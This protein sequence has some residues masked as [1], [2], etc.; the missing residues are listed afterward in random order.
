VICHSIAS[1]QM[2][3]WMGAFK[4]WF[5]VVYTTVSG[6]C[7]CVDSSVVGELGKVL[8]LK[9]VEGYKSKNVYNV[10]RLPCD[11]TL[12]WNGGFVVVEIIPSRG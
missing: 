5:S 4:Q 12:V 9:T 1:G 8:L 10:I 3:R 7:T 11:K 2:D 6:E